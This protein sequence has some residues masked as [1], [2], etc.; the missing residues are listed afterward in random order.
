MA[1]GK[2]AVDVKKHLNKDLWGER[3]EVEIIMRGF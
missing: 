2:E 3:V 1:K